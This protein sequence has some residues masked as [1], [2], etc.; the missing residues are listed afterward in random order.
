MR[1]TRLARAL[2]YPAYEVMPMSNA[3]TKKHVYAAAVGLLG[4]LT[5]L[6]GCT[7]PSEDSCPECTEQEQEV[8]RCGKGAW[9]NAD[10]GTAGDG[11]VAPT[12]GGAQGDAAPVEAAT[13]DASDAGAAVTSGY[14]NA[15]NTG[16]RGTRT[17]YTGPM[18]I[19][20]DNVVLENLII[21]Q[22]DL[23]IM[24]ANPI[25]RNCEFTSS[26]YWPL[27]VTGTVAAPGLVSNCTFRTGPNSQCSVE[28]SNAK[29]HRCDVSGSPDGIRG[30]SNSTATD[31]Y[32]HDLYVSSSTHNDGIDFEGNVNMTVMHNTVEVDAGQTSCIT[33]TRW[34][35]SDL[36][37]NV[38][39]EDNLLAGAGYSVYGPGTQSGPVTN[40]RIINNKFS[41]KYYPK[42]GYWGWIAYEPPTGQGNM[43]SGNT[44]FATGASL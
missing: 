32:V 38:L 4:L 1:E 24:G 26:T 14:P 13:A 39:V 42:Y 36:F 37:N 27:R 21:G 29:I 23:T 44:D 22:G 35:G 18:V 6:G 7:D 10:S 20:Q 8:R 34:S 17:P 30:S 12:D 25:V 11:A 16:A 15:T 5:L 19:Q 9:C 28:V 31:N 2:L 33:V 3:R 43:V 40:T 41:K